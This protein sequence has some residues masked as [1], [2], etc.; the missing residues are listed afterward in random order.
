M[1]IGV[2]VFLIAVGA[3][4]AFATDVSVSGLDLDVVGVILMVA[5]A[6]GLAVTLLVWSSRQRVTHVERSVVDRPGVD[7]RTVVEDRPVV[8]RR[9]VVED[10][11]VVEERRRYE[12]RRYDEPPL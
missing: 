11:P 8:E 12:D 9:S 6:I 4:L 3:I 7:R 2:S 5:G 1:G 10:R